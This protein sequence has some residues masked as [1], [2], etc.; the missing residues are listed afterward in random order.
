MCSP[1]ACLLAA[2]PKRVTGT[3]APPLCSAPVHT[4]DMKSS[5]NPPTAPAPSSLLQLKGLQRLHVGP[6]DLQLHAGECVSVMGPSGAGKSVLLRMIAD[7]DPH[8]GEAWLN[9]AACSAMPAPQWRKQVTYVPAESG[10]WSEEVRAHFPPQFDFA[11]WLP[12]L[13]LDPQAGDWPVDR[14]STGE[15][16]R[17]ALL[18]ALRPDGKVLLLDEPTSGLDENAV[19][20][21]ENL[22][23]MQMQEHRIAIL[24]VTHSQAQADRMAA[25]QT[26]LHNGALIE[27]MQESALGATA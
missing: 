8:A 21:V 27:R 5:G 15:R 16:Q 14:L 25:R 12:L 3:H 19:L 11:R 22:L 24:M 13:G 2:G 4:P 6:I 9:D 20:A 26:T 18:R 7:L 10:W 17:L 1:C 23:R